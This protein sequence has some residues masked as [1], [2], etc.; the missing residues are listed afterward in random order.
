MILKKI[1]KQGD[2]VVVINLM[3]QH[4]FQKLQSYPHPPVFSAL[5]SVNGDIGTSAG[6]YSPYPDKLRT[7]LLLVMNYGLHVFVVLDE[8]FLALGSMSQQ[9]ADNTF[10]I[11]WVVFELRHVHIR[12]VLLGA[13]W[14]SVTLFTFTRSS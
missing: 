1:L 5:K 7:Q 4:I 13:P 8:M 10:S 2:G 12:L 6:K 9:T 3:G 11:G 14:H